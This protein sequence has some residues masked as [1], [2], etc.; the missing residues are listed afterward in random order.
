MSMNVTIFDPDVAVY[1]HQSV[2]RHNIVVGFGGWPSPHTMWFMDEARFDS[3][4]D[5]LLAA[6]MEW[7]TKTK[8]A[9]PEELTPEPKEDADAGL[10]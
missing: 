3:L 7:I 6:K 4:I 5:N 2:G 1:I 9:N 8:G 10:W